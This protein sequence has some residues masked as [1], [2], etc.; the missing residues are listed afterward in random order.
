MDR[1]LVLGKMLFHKAN[2][3]GA[4]Q[5]KLALLWD[6]D[7]QATVFDIFRKFF[8]DTFTAPVYR[9]R[10]SIDIG[11]AFKC[12]CLSAANPLISSEQFIETYGYAHTLLSGA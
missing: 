3:E 7:A 1:F 9:P 11:F 12:A 10:V 5:I 4:T 8:V 2:D 6:S